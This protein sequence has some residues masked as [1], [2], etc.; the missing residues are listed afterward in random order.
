MFAEVIDLLQDI[1]LEDID[2]TDVTMELLDTIDQ[3]T[4]ELETTHV[5]TIDLILT[6]YLLHI[7]DM[8]DHLATMAT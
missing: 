3:L 6:S 8:E 4:L 2:Q 7:E 1:M 5:T